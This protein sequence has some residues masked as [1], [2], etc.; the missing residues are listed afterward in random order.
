MSVRLRSCISIFKRA[1]RPPR[2]KKGEERAFYCPLR[3]QISS[4]L[5][6]VMNQGS[7]CRLLKSHTLTIKNN[8]KGK[9]QSGKRMPVNRTGLNVLSKHYTQKKWH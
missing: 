8:S 7:V 5:W 2:D 4:R 6:A 9:E 1:K 3:G